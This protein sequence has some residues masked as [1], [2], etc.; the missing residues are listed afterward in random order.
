MA[1]PDP[2]AAGDRRCSD[3]PRRVLFVEPVA[4]RGGAE[5]VLL[6][7]ILEM[8]RRRFL[9]YAALL[10]QGPL[11]EEARQ[12]GATVECFPGHRVR[13]V[14]ATARAVRWLCR[15][16]REWSIDLV[17]T[18]GTK[19]HLYG[20]LVRLLTGVPEV[21]H[22]YDEPPEP[23]S[24]IDR[25]TTRI[26]FDHAI[27]ISEAPRR[28]FC[29]L[30]AVDRSTMVHPGVK[31][32]TPV[33]PG[34]IEQ[35][36]AGL[37]L[38]MAVPLILQISRLQAFKGHEHLIRA[39]DLVRR[40]HPEARVLM[41]GGTL[42]GLEEEYPDRLRRLI[43]ELGL[44][45]TVMMAGELPDTAVAALLEHCR[46]L[47]YAEVRGP[48]SLVILEAMARGKPVVAARTDGSELI[49]DHGATGT[50]VPPA[51]PGTLGAAL[52][53]I[54]DR[55]DLARSLGEAGFSRWQQKFSVD[56]MV[57]RTQEVYSSLLGR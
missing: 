45:R 18:Q 21:W 49:V 48:Y 16:V 36:L 17:H 43:V 15:L 13:N 41:V 14:V 29:K 31:P 52:V 20:G 53:E 4:H 40:R 11:A 39:A 25:V 7:L 32:A 12:A 56:T 50:L 10:D 55:P 8:D 37:G 42:F 35:V 51:D 23:P 1:T 19:T 47:C 33:D 2:D 26:P 27:F 24:W 28:G 22:L 54:L 6:D 34:A 44:E 5:V 57:T 3:G 9:P 38:P 46:C 30:M